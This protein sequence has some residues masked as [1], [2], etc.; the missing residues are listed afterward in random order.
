MTALIKS[1]VPLPR[2]LTYLAAVFDQYGSSVAELLFSYKADYV[3]HPKLYQSHW[4]NACQGLELHRSL[5]HFA[6][7]ADR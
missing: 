5:P 6:D 1:S 4:E 2:P 3:G 7:A